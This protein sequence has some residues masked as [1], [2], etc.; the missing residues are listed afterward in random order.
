M[1][2]NIYST[3]VSQRVAAIDTLRGIIMVVMALDHVRDFFSNV[4]YEP[5]EL[6]HA[7]T[8]LFLTRWVTHFC[9]PV[10]IF[11]S[12][13]SAY[14]SFRHKTKKQAS[15]ILLTRG[16]WLIVLEF[17]IVQFGWSFNFYYHVI[18][19]QVLWAI[20]W[21]MIYLAVMI[22][23]PRPLIMIIGLL[24][25]GGHN[26]LDGV[27]AEQFGHN[28]IWWDVLHQQAMIQYGGRM[29]GVFYPL[30]PWLGVL[31]TGYCLGPLFTKNEQTRH[32]YLYAIGLGC[33]AL[34]ILLRAVNAYGDPSPWQWQGNLHRTFLSFINCA[35]YPPSLL[36]LLMTL[37]PAI[38]A[39]PLLER[40]T[41][42]V[43]EV[44][45]VYG[46]V[47]LFYYILHLPLIHLLAVFTAK[48]L[49][50]S[51]SIFF[52][53]QLFA[54][55]NVAWGVSLPWVYV[56]WV[57]TVF[58]LYFPCRWYMKLKMTHKKWWMSYL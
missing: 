49:H 37:G 9:A 4:H 3:Q 33:I 11:L 53:D 6:Y 47:P 13:V 43:T 15:W 34:F 26:M 30:V 14:L 32:K 38:A 1:P 52:N 17:T 29:V 7:S 51:T 12:G 44:F 16:L 18:L 8:A 57:V 45:A 42:R 46:R 36:Y 2:T 56:A 41:G 31:S 22:Y 25:I 40:A 54:D 35:K 58:I 19:A 5:T 21:C 28:A 23:L 48:A 27:R 20:G 24:M 39:M 10:F 50:F 55:P